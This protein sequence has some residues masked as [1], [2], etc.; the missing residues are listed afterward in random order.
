MR[1][2][3]LAKKLSRLDYNVNFCDGCTFTHEGSGTTFGKNPKTP[4]EFLFSEV[5]IKKKLKIID[6]AFVKLQFNVF[7]LLC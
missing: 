3:F 1:L 7:L 4:L 5:K 2:V 6:V